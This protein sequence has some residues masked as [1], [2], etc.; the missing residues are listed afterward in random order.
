MCVLLVAVCCRVDTSMRVMLGSARHQ[1]SNNTPIVG[2][3]VV[4]Q[5]NKMQ[6]TSRH[7]PPPSFAKPVFLFVPV[8]GHLVLQSRLLLLLLGQ[9][10]LL[11]LMLLLLVLV[12]STQGGTQHKTPHHRQDRAVQNTAQQSRIWA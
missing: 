11:L 9:A 4:S 5:H 10:V 3:G 12:V 6:A 1:E 7:R 2:W 8:C